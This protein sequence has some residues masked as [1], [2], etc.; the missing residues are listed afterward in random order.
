MI[1]K[2]E[3]ERNSLIAMGHLI[4]HKWFAESAAAIVGNLIAESY[5]DPNTG[6]GDGG[7]AMGIAQWRGSRLKKFEEIIGKHCESASLIEQLDFVNWELR[8]SEKKAGNLL[9]KAK[10]LEEKTAVIDKYYERS[11]GL[12]LERRVKHANNALN[13]WNTTQAK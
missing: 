4:K 13:A 9:K 8:N 10:T 7:T 6:R 3:K 12:H 11:A 2:Q 5:L 1:S